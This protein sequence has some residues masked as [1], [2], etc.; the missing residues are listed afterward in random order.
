MAWWTGWA[1]AW[2]L[3]V[4]IAYWL[5]RDEIRDRN[6]EWSLGDRRL[7]FLL[8]LFLGPLVV[9]SWLCPFIGRGLDDTFEYLFGDDRPANW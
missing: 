9:V 7:T 5:V 8:C 6:G 4:V 1:A 3:C 2:M